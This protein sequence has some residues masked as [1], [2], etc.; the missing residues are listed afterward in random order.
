MVAAARKATSMYV[1]IN[2]NMHMCMHMWHQPCE[3][4]QY[5]HA[6]PQ[7]VWHRR[8]GTTWPV[9]TTA[10]K[11][12][13]LSIPRVKRSL[14]PRQRVGCPSP[15]AVTTMEAPVTTREPTLKINGMHAAAGRTAPTVTMELTTNAAEG[16]LVLAMLLLLVLTQ[17]AM[18]CG[19]TQ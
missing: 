8:A 11:S 16:S 7:R 13:R 15:S 1:C 2:L 6:H 14:T 18:A 5:Q 9:A 17:S 4:K 12:I 10:T 19:M 3:L